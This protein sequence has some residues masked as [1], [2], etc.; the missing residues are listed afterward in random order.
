MTRLAR[1]ERQ[2][3]VAML[4]AEGMSTRAIAPIVGVDR[5]TVERDV[6][7]GTNVPPI[8]T[9]EGLDGKT[10]PRQGPKPAPTEP[11]KPKGNHEVTIVNDTPPPP[12]KQHPPT[13][14]PHAPIFVQD[15]S[16][17]NFWRSL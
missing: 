7:G 1:G 15:F 17:L 12:R 13:A 9:V 4:S 5:K 3:M 8:E 6:R 10:Y 14:P 16:I 11:A 2:E